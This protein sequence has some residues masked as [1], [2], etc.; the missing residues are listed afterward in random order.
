MNVKRL[1]VALFLLALFTIAVRETLDPDM[2]WHL[3]TGEYILQAG[4]PRHDVFSFTVPD[5]EWLTHEWLSQVFMWSVYRVGGLPGLMVVFALLTAVSFFLVYRVSAGRPYLAAFVVLLGAFASAIVWG[6]RP[7]IF[8]TLFTAV[9]IYIVERYRKGEAGARTLWWLPVV[10]MVWANFHSGYLLGVVY[11]AVFTLGEA[12]EIVLQ[13]RAPLE[14]PPMTWSQVRGLAGITA[15]SFLAAAINPNGPEMWIYPFLTLGSS[16]MQT[17]IVE[18]NSPDFHQ[19]IF[20][21]FLALGGLGVMGW[22]FG[23]RRP[24]L[25]DLLLFGGTAFAG[26]VSAR[27]IPLFAIIAPPIVCRAL[28]G[29]LAVNPRLAAFLQEPA[30]PPRPTARQTTL[31]AAV[32]VLALV[33]VLIWTLDIVAGNETAVAE[34]FP[35]TAVAYL[36]ES[37]L[38]EKHGYNSYNW[39]GYLIWEGIPVFIDG[40][41][42]VYGDQF[43]L[44]YLQAY[45]AKENWQEPLAE[46]D[47]D[48]VLMEKGQPLNSLLAVSPDWQEVYQDDLSQIFV[49]VN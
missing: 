30:A 11:L 29:W 15:V 14:T 19:R 26:F 39:G 7:Q 35:V 40:R 10:T 47:V 20:W 43:M 32:L 25:S 16:A 27:N 8:N 21:P 45:K 36:K 46:Y 5:H 42:D 2:W 22:A 24:R 49:P 34:N 28:V 3:R 13:P 18:W 33:A 23:S 38:A 17:Y 1:F 41:A 12:L 48:Y 37:G 4:I 9:F 6:V 31:H 44:F